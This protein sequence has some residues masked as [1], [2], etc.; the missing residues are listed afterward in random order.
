MEQKKEELEIT[1]QTS[2]AIV[3][4]LSVETVK[5][6]EQ[7]EQKKKELEEKTQEM[8]VK[9]DKKSQVVEMVSQRNAEVQDKRDEIE[10]KSALIVYDN[11][12]EVE[13]ELECLAQTKRQK[14]KELSES[15]EEL[16]NTLLRKE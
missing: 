13:N 12:L 3:K 5:I 4:D 11:P 10:A 15:K 7:T 1:R 8:N 2:I 14:L 9:N 6:K 16:G